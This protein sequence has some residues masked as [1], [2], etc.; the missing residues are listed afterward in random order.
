MCLTGGM[1]SVIL[2]LPF[3]LCIWISAGVVI[4]YTLLGGLYSVAYTD[5]IQLTLIFVTLVS[6]LHFLFPQNQNLQR[7]FQNWMFKMNFFFCLQ[8][9]CFPF[10]VAN[11][12]VV[13][14]RKTLMN[15]TLHAP[16]IGQPDL[17]KG[18]III[19]HFLFFVRNQY[20]FHQIDF[21]LQ[22]VSRVTKQNPITISS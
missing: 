1:T 16:W 21:S 18:W 2:D 13:D 20:S 15:N 4:I 5:V 22:N 12:H 10:I 19:D 17:K 3:S 6:S 14:I 8:W 7:T 9:V 11:P